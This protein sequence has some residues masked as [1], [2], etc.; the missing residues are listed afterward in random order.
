MNADSDLQSPALTIPQS[1]SALN[2]HTQVRLKREG[3]WLLLIL[4]SASEIPGAANWHELWEQLKHRLNGGDRFWQPQTAVELITQDQ[5]LDTQKLQEIDD[6]L[7]QVE[8]KLRRVRTNRRQTAVAA[9]TAGYSVEQQTPQNSLQQT[10][11][12]AAEPMAEAL[13]LQITVR[14]GVE[15]RHPGT[16][17]I[18]GDLNPGG[19]LI[20]AGD[21]LVW[22]RLRGVAHAGA[23]GNRKARI[24]ALQMEP[25]QL[26]IADAVARA[27][28][29]SPEQF[30]PEVA[31]V[32]PEGI[33]IAR[34]ADF[35]KTHFLILNK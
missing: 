6:A 3:E 32:S 26:R 21:I 5:L 15:I 23:T 34:A 4:P 12:E 22:G 30:H 20:A 9:A 27:P 11:F 31:Y 25:T 18:I 24:M 1:D 33:R 28:E 35:A 10:P 7:S 17:V 2:C 14:S 29:T 8:L 19:S 13:C 16:I